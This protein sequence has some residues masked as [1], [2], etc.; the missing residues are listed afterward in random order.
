MDNTTQA[1]LQFDTATGAFLKFNMQ[2]GDLGNMRQGLF[3][4][5]AC[6]MGP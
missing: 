5:L 2:H 6:V 3:L 4:N 1:F